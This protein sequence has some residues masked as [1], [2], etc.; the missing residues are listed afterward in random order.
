MKATG[1]T[2]VENGCGVAKQVLEGTWEQVALHAEQLSGRRVSLTIL[3]GGLCAK[4]SSG[5]SAP[6]AMLRRGMFPQLNGLTDEAFQSAEWRGE[7]P[8]KL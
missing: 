1:T 2:Q 3:D 5:S 8:D 7:D 4:N 6:G